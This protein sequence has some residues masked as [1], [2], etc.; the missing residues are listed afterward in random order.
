MMVKMFY[1]DYE[2][3]N[4]LEEA[5]AEEAPLEEFIEEVY[6]LD[7]DNISYIGLITEQERYKIKSDDYDSYVIYKFDDRSADYLMID[8]GDFE[9]CKSFIIS[10]FPVKDLAS[11]DK[12][13]T[14]RGNKWLPPD[15]NKN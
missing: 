3:E 8:L 6:E 9:K 14:A 10:Q 15:W 2:S 11:G 5:D 12:I 7:D 4:I 13:E 1:Y